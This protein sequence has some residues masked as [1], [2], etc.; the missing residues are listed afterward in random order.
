MKLQDKTTVT[1][2]SNLHTMSN[3]GFLRLVWFFFIC[4]YFI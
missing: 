4:C 1:N 2:Y 3:N